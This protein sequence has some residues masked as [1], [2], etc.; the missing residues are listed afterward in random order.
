MPDSCAHMCAMS[1]S[2]SAGR[3]LSHT[4]HAAAPECRAAMS[5]I[6]SRRRLS[7]SSRS[8]AHALLCSL[9]SRPIS[10]HLRRRSSDPSASSAPSPSDAAAGGRRWLSIKLK[11]SSELPAFGL[12]TIAKQC[13]RTCSNNFC[14]SD[15]PSSRDH[16]D[17][18]DSNPGF[19]RRANSTACNLDS[20]A[21]TRNARL[22]C[23]AI[24]GCR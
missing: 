1:C 17:A 24:S 21:G 12:P 8:R 11:K 5:S 20:S 18:N 9:R 4:G 10:V 13:R 14:A 16:L 15:T 3:A 19:C 6:E 23:G 2:G 22:S 7:G